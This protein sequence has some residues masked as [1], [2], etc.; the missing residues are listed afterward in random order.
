MIRPKCVTNIKVKLANVDKFY[1]LIK[2]QL[3]YG[4]KK[5]AQE[6][7][8]EATDLI[9][10]AWGMEWRL[11]EMN[12]RLLRFKNVMREKDLLKLATECYLVWLQ[13][14]FHL[15]KSHDTDTNNEN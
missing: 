14:G 1:A 15:E 13:M 8:K 2:D 12:K 9:C 10:E 3:E 4:A 11:G 5:Y 7:D 6:E